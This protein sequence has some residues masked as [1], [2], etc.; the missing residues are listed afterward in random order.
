MSL[1]LNTIFLFSVHYGKVENRNND[2]YIRK[3]LKAAM[4]KELAYLEEKRQIEQEAKL[5]FGDHM[6]KAMRSVTDVRNEAYAS[7]KKK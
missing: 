5:I 2:E 4:K 7:G 1:A 3:E 6:S